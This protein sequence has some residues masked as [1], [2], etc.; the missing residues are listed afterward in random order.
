MAAYIARRLALMIPTLVGITL[1]VF[2]LIALSPGG[3]GA[4]VTSTPSSSDSAIV[5]PPPQ[6]P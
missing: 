6:T 2:M 3:I 5:R 4:D 1:L